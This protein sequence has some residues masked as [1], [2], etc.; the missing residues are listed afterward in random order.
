MASRGPRTGESALFYGHLVGELVRRVDG[1]SL[2]RFLR[3]EV[4]LDFAVGLTPREQ[5]RA[6]DLTGLDARF[7]AENWPA[8]PRSTAGHREPA[9]ARRRRTS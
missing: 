3:D 9:G 2:G 5:A 7:R 4:G 1:R 8:V 6:V